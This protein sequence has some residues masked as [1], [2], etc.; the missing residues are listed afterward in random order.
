MYVN[1]QET[2]KLKSFKGFVVL[3]WI[4]WYESSIR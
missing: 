2:E 4:N 1:I 3:Y